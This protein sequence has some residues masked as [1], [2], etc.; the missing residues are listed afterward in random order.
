MA[1]LDEEYRENYL[2]DLLSFYKKIGLP[3]RLK[4]LDV[5]ME[6]MDAVIDKGIETGEIEHSPYDI[7]H[8]MIKKL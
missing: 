7:N 3:I 5:E 2:D 6:E 4:D 1:F 8:N